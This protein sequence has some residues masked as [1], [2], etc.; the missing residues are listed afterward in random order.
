[1]PPPPHRVVLDHGA[2]REIRR[3]LAVRERLPGHGRGVAAAVKPASDGVGLVREPVR[4]DVRVP[5][6]LLRSQWGRAQKLS[7][8]VPQIIP[9]YHK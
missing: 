7:C 9:D 8:T 3:E 5:H 6:E 4:R 1:V 2:K